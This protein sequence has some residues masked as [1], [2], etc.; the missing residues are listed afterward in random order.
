MQARVGALLREVARVRGVADVVSPYSA[1]G[2]RQI[3]RDGTVA[4]ATVDF[5]LGT[6]DIP[7]ATTDRII[8]LAEH[9]HVVPAIHVG[10]E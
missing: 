2:A 7:Q 8:A 10:V 9:A 5:A 3:A 6:G 1:A 4:Y